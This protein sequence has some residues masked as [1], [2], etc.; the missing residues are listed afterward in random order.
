ML[1]HHTVS[2]VF[3]ILGMT[4]ISMQTLLPELQLTQV[5]AQSQ[6]SLQNQLNESIHNKLRE[7]K[8]PSHKSQFLSNLDITSPESIPNQ[9]IYLRT[10]NSFTQE[11]TPSIYEGMSLVSGLSVSELTEIIELDDISSIQEDS[12]SIENTQAEY[13]Q[14][15]QLYNQEKEFFRNLARIRQEA[16]IYEIFTDDNSQNSGFDLITDLK[17]IEKK[18]F[19][20]AAPSTIS[21]AS[22]NRANFW[23]N[24][25]SQPFVSNLSPVN[26]TSFTTANNFSTTTPIDSNN[27]PN[28]SQPSILEPTPIYQFPSIKYGSICQIDPEF[29][30]EIDIFNSQNDTDSNASSS[31]DTETDNSSDSQSNSDNPTPTSVATQVANYIPQPFQVNFNNPNQS[32][33]ADQVFCFTQELK[34]N[35]VDLIYPDGSDCVSCIVN[36]LNKTLQTLLDNGVLPQKI[37]GNFAEPPLCKQAAYGK[38]GLNLNIFSRPILPEQASPSIIQNLNPSSVESSSNQQ[39]SPTNSGFSI[40]NDTQTQTNLNLV[41]QTNAQEFIKQFDQKLNSD[42][43]KN[44]QV[45]QIIQSQQQHFDKLGQQINTLNL[46]FESFNTSLDQINQNFTEL[47]NLPEC[48]AL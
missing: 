35:Q 30:E 34:Y 3:L 25:N 7:N 4:I 20:E 46:Y 41:A 15:I 37:T 13:L 19:Q 14:I 23:S 28:L 6:V 5:F 39:K 12:S 32:C 24:Y 43:S 48:S 47:I 45:T 36:R 27:S 22:A 2:K 11:L 26:F 16:A 9:N 40:S 33:P 29:K 44:N 8:Q 21:Y 10:L 38:I 17:N 18:L 42:Y 31:E 1:R